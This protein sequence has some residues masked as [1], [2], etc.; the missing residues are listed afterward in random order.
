MEYVLGS[1]ITLAILSISARVLR[2]KELS[3]PVKV[4]VMFNQTRK[5]ELIRDMLPFLPPEHKPLVSQASK[6]R[7]DVST[8][9]M[10]IDDMAYWIENDGL[11]E[12][13]LQDGG[14]DM[15]TKKKVDIMSMDDVELKKMIFVV[16]KLTEGK[17]NDSGTSGN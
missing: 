6:H 16:E 5:L 10:F 7:G 13:V 8:K 12:A 17:I 4:K 11:H 2:V 1:L 9:V 15:E 3:K 14:V